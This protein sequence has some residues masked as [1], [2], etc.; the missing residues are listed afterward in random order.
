[1]NHC[2]LVTISSGRVP[3]S[4]NFT[5]CSIGLGAPSIPPAARN[6]STTFACACFMFR[7]AISP[8][9]DRPSGESRPA[10]GMVEMRPSFSTTVRTGKPSSRHQTTSVVSP[11]VQIIAMP[12][13]FS[14]SA[15]SWATTGTRT[16]NSGVVTSVPISGR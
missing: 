9:A 13:P 6:S 7:P 16:L 10:G 8:Y 4:Q 11:N 14:G 3:F 1:M 5:G 2:R 15:S 12:D